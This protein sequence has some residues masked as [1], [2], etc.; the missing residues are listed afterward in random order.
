MVALDVPD[1]SS[2]QTFFHGFPHEAFAQLREHAP[3]WWR[4]FAAPRSTPATP[5]GIALTAV[6]PSTIWR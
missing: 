3:V 4:C 2:Y 5:E 6:Q 1:L